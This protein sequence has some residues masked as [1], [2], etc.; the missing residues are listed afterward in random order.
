MRKKDEERIEFGN[1]CLK[2]CKGGFDSCQFRGDGID[3][4]VLKRKC[5]IK[6]GKVKK[7]RKKRNVTKS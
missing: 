4:L 7:K 2:Q 3:W 1:W 5:V 6:N